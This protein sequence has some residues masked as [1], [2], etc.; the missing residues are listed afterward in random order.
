MSI[1]IYFLLGA[2]TFFIL[3]IIIGLLSPRIIKVERKIEVAGHPDEVFDQ[4]SNFQE[5]V[6]WNPWTLKDPN[7]QQEFIGSPGEIGA[8]YTWQGNKQVG[9][10]SMQIT[11]IKK[12]NH[13]E[14]DLNFGPRGN[15]KCGFNLVEKGNGTEVTWYFLSDIGKNPL[16]RVMG[17]MMD[18]FIGKDYEQGLK[19]LKNK[20][21]A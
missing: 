14:M 20:F 5:F 6:Q 18:R 17:R 8:K 12:P 4:V 19:N 13:V 21:Q 11:E 16:S 9:K 10:G 3:L 7:I 2:I 15:A 1:L